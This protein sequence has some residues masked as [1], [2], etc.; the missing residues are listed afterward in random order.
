MDYTSSETE[1]LLSEIHTGKYHFNSISTGI[2]G[3]AKAEER[4][5]I[6]R[7][8]NAVSPEGPTVTEIKRNWFNMEKKKK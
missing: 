7:T 4:E 3:P 1:V 2:K 6:T 5:K 8:V